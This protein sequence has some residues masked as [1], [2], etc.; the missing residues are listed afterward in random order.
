MSR[1]ALQE[2]V[3]VRQH[4]EEQA[5]EALLRAQRALADAR[6]ALAAAEKTLADYIQWRIAEERK[7]LD[8]LMRRVLRL[9]EIS[10]VRQE[11]AL[12]RDREFELMDTVRKAEAA[13]TKAEQLVAEARARQAQAVR[14]LEK[15]LEHRTLWAEEERRE[16]EKMEERELEDLSRQAALLD[17]RETPYERN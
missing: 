6:Q 5:S 16:Q 10:D 7:M 12:L 14:D 17:T 11:I 2:L 15:L 13:V 9:G 4:R 1:Y 8:G 3:K